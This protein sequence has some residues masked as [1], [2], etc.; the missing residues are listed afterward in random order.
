MATETGPFGAY[1]TYYSP[2]AFPLDTIYV[3]SY[4]E[5]ATATAAAAAT[6]P[7][8]DTSTQ[9]TVVAADP[10]A[11]PEPTGTKRTT[12]ELQRTERVAACR[13]IDAA[14][15]STISD[16][17][18]R[19]DRDTNDD[20]LV[21]TNVADYASQATLSGC[22]LVGH[23][24][25]R[26]CDQPIHGAP[27]DDTVVANL[28]FHR[29]VIDAYNLLEPLR[30]AVATDVVTAAPQ[31]SVDDEDDENDDATTGAALQVIRPARFTH[32][33]CFHDMH[34]WFLFHAARRGSTNPI[35]TKILSVLPYLHPQNVSPEL[36]TRFA[37]L[38]AAS[39]GLH[40]PRIVVP[41]G[42]EPDEPRTIPVLDVAT[43]MANGEQV[44]AEELQAAYEA[45]QFRYEQQQA[46][47]NAVFVAAPPTEA[48]SELPL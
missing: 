32:N 43:A 21:A 30:L 11:A 13:R 10:T 9:P 22:G 34:C 38:H 26:F 27:F 46:L 23:G 29:N 5:G 14:S 36:Q 20:I 45:E 48:P 44:T 24:A 6:S 40:A 12:D 42:L 33:N 16:D 47:A 2:L 35:I 4:Q 28:L 25:C 7:P 1:A 39:E 8:I 3:Q 37:Q 41:Y 19:D 31:A 18:M 15:S 17:A